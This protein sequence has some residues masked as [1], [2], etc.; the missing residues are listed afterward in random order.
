MRFEETNLKSENDY[1]EFG[2]LMINLKYLFKNTLI[3]K[4][5]T[6]YAPVP[7]FR[8]PKI[9]NDLIDELLYIFDTNEIDYEKLRELSEYENN[10]FRDLIMKSGLYR[11]L[12]YKYDKTR[13]KL[14]DII[15]DYEILKG[16]IEAGNDNPELL[17][18][19]KIVLKKLKNY[20]K[21]NEDQYNEILE[22]L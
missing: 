19:A 1:K 2:K 5:K 18:K 13:Q 22:D 11:R 10:L 3:V 7:G 14:K 6:S 16:E 4:Y 17:I 15:E 9:S 20:G 12:K 21:I 8:R